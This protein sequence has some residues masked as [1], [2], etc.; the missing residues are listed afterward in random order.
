MEPYV[1]STSYRRLAMK[2]PKTRKDVW[3]TPDQLAKRF[4]YLTPRSLAWQ[5][6]NRVRN[7]LAPHVRIKPGRRLI[8]ARGYAAWVRSKTGTTDNEGGQS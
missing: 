7:G 6:N 5:L 1:A 2:E 3:L 4:K 8:N